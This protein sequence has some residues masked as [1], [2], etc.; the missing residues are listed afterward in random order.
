M[1]FGSLARF[2]TC[3][4][5]TKYGFGQQ[6]KFMSHVKPHVRTHFPINY[7]KNVSSKRGQ[8]KKK[9]WNKMLEAS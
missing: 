9:F 4:V 7:N 2:S 8:C 6:N 3:I 5:H 1:T